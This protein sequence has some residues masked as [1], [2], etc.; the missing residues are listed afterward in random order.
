MLGPV[1]RLLARGRHGH[2]CDLRDHVPRAVQADAVAD[3]QVQSRDVRG[4]VQRRVAHRDA[5]DLDRVHV[6]A[7][8][9]APT[10]ANHDLDRAQGRHSLD[11]RKLVRVLPAHRA[12][13]AAEALTQGGIVELGHDAIHVEGDVEALGLQLVVVREAGR[14][15]LDPL[16]VPRVGDP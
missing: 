6:R 14:E 16:A 1:G 15:P 12:R 8:R 7:R 9:Q 11:R 3:R 5:A 2:A 10:D 4:V 13:G